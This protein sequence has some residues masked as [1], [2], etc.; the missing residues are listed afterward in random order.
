[1][2]II[3]VAP[4]TDFT[5]E[6]LLA[7][8]SEAW[9]SFVICPI[10][11]KFQVA[12]RNLEKGAHFSIATLDTPDLCQELFRRIFTAVENCTAIGN[13]DHS[14]N[15]DCGASSQAEVYIGLNNVGTS[16]RRT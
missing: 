4:D 11:N 3:P 13:L 10:G 1:M 7:A 8:N 2:R 6:T 9:D 15:Q 14:L 12:L 16:L 5:V